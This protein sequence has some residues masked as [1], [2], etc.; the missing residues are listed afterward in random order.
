MLELRFARYW[1]LANLSGMFLVLAATLIPAH[2]LWPDGSLVSWGLSDKWL[3]GI[4]FAFL[5]VWFCGQYTKSAYWRVAIGLLAFGVL[6]ELCQQALT[7]RTADLR[8]LLANLAGIATG[9]L[10]AAV[11]VGGWSVRVEN[12]LDKRIE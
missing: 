6:I 7:Y 9:L 10:I 3:H 1:Q 12:W 4:T 11:G 5:A 8:D 2:W